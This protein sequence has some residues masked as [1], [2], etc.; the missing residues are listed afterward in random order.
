MGKIVINL[1]VAR[2]G[3]VTSIPEQVYSFE[4]PENFNVEE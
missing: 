2:N 3:E 1:S 4:T